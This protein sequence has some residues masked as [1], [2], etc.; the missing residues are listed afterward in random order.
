MQDMMFDNDGHLQ[1]TVNQ[2]AEGV[3]EA[4]T[5]VY[6]KNKNRA[7]NWR[8][9][10]GALIYS[11]PPSVEPLSVNGSPEPGMWLSLS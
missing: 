7:S 8:A 9:V 11:Q 10:V 5:G 3:P 6:R 2:F 1:R 4:V